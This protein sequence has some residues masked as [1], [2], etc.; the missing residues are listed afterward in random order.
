ML[1]DHNSN[2]NSKLIKVEAGATIQDPTDGVFTGYALF[3]S[4]SERLAFLVK[5]TDLPRSRTESSTAFRRPEMSMNLDTFWLA[6]WRNFSTRIQ[7]LDFSLRRHQG[8]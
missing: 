7:E 8:A 2:Y 3:D 4:S 5:T 1:P 6:I